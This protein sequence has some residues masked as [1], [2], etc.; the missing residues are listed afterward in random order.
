MIQNINLQCGTKGYNN[1]K[2]K[3]FKIILGSTTLILICILIIKLIKAPTFL[4]PTVYSAGLI[5][6]IVLFISLII[7]GLCKVLLKK[8]SFMIVLCC[9]IS[10]SCLFLL[11]Q[12]N[13][14]AI[15][16]VVPKG[17]YGKINLVLSNTKTN[18]LN[19]DTNGIGY[20]NRRTFDE[21]F[22]KPIVFEE[23]GTDISKQVVGF[24]PST[25]WGKES[26][27]F[28]NTTKNEI[29]IT[30]VQSL[31]FEIVPKDKIGQKQYYSNDLLNLLDKNKIL[32]SK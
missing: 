23:D 9:T 30:E 17:F 22:A 8:A 28:V 10:G 18:I 11:S 6:I 14:Q 32:N 3:T 16:I 5:T 13:S 15:K 31:T 26:T 12:F 19:V 20:I 1:M 27:S 29:G 21:T 7:S 2:T 24:N 4:I 25:F